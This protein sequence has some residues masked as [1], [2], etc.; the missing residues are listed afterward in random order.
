MVNI[1]IVDRLYDNNLFR[2][3]VAV[4]SSIKTHELG[5]TYMEKMDRTEIRELEMLI[6]N[7]IDDDR[8]LTILSK[9]FYINGP[10]PLEIHHTPISLVAEYTARNPS[11]VTPIFLT[12]LLYKSLDILVNYHN[13]AMIIGLPYIIISL[14]ELNDHSKLHIP[15]IPFSDKMSLVA[16]IANKINIKE[17]LASTDWRNLVKGVLILGDYER[18]PKYILSTVHHTMSTDLGLLKSIIGRF[19]G[20]VRSEELMISF[21][22]LRAIQLVRGE[23]PSSIEQSYVIF[24]I[25]PKIIQ[26][27]ILNHLCIFGKNFRLIPE[28]IGF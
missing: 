11:D 7:V 25:A 23:L 6:L 2:K 1:S 10:H 19:K 28:R 15:E 20:E 12:K 22:I 18:Y 5:Y 26:L 21:Y 17:Q 27:Y 24:N 13:T 16:N 4:S 8:L 9:E 3:L 14:V